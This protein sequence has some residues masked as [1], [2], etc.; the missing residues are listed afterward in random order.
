MQ[1]QNINN[2][3][4]Q[5]GYKFIRMSKEAKEQLPLIVP[6]GKLVFDSF[7][8]K[9]SNVFLVARDS[10][11]TKIVNF[12][13][14]NNLNYRYYPDIKTYNVRYGQPEKVS[15]MIASMKP[16]KINFEEALKNYHPVQEMRKA[17]VRALK[18]RVKE[19]SSTYSKNIVKALGLD[20]NDM[21]VSTGARG[22]T[23]IDNNAKTRRITIS[24]PTTNN[25]HYVFV[26]NKIS[27]P[28][29]TF[30]NTLPSDILVALS[31]DSNNLVLIPS[32]K[33]I[34]SITTSIL[35]LVFL[36]KFISSDKS[37]NSSFTRTLT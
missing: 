20:S 6:K 26:E 9:K 4:F 19:Q 32:F 22:I 27:S 21:V 33:T 10:F 13:K 17:E 16:E 8:G 14:E 31:I 36:S 37:I 18:K 3:N 15:E 11:H 34:L 24:P 29:T 35:S 7:E 25:M 12:I 1:I 5:G 30:T 23:V 2:T 28:P